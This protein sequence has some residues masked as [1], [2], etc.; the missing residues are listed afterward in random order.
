L[1]R[2]QTIWAD[3]AYGMYGGELI[4]WVKEHYGWD[5]EMVQKP[6]EQKGFVVI[7]LCGDQETLGGGT[8]LCPTRQRSPSQQ[9][10]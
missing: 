5:L 7:R 3:G 4:R 8:H 1:E 6:A 9:R 2:L 10:L